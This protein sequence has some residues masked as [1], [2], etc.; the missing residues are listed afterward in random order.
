[1]NQ[2]ASSIPFDENA[3]SAARIMMGGK[4]MQGAG[5]GGIN[6]R[7]PLAAKSINSNSV[8][9][10]NTNAAPRRALGDIT[11]QEGSS[12]SGKGLGKDSGAPLKARIGNGSSSLVPSTRPL[13]TKVIDSK[14]KQAA[15]KRVTP[16]HHAPSLSLP[17]LPSLNPSSM[18]VDLDSLDDDAPIQLTGHE[19]WLNVEGSPGDSMPREDDDVDDELAGCVALAQKCIGQNL[20]A[21]PVHRPSS[22]IPWESP[23]A[24]AD[25]LPSPADFG[26]IDDFT[27]EPFE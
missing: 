6:Q 10:K 2:V 18:S 8:G 26:D 25:A 19:S 9:G 5:L 20:I 4:R 24:D 1:M 27:F 17:S 14:P 21:P 11:N 7:Q 3:T 16:I 13:Q 15:P 12:N 23:R 22:P